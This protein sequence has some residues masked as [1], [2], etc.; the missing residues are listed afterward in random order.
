MKV[1]TTLQM[2]MAEAAA[3]ANGT[4]YLRLMENA[5]AACARAIREEYAISSENPKRI[6]VVCGRGNNGGDGYAIAR[7]LHL[8]GYLNI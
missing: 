8:K 1:L 6:T 5:G 4:S 7:L 2:R 3:N